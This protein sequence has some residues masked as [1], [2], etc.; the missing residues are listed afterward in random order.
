[1]ANGLGEEG[2]ELERLDLVE[3]AQVARGADPDDADRQIDLPDQT[4]QRRR[5]LELVR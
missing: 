2:R 1:M 4:D 3:H 5:H